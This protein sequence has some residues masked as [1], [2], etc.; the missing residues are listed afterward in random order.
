VLRT[1]SVDQSQLDHLA[2]R[3]GGDGVHLPVDL[4]T[5]AEEYHP[6]LRDAGIER[7][8]GVADLA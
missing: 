7:V 1:F 8:F 2:F 3:G 4:A 5:D 6:A